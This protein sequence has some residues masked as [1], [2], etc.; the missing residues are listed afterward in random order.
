MLERS[1][2]SPFVDPFLDS[3]VLTARAF[4][5]VIRA[6]SLVTLFFGEVFPRLS[7]PWPDFD[8]SGENVLLAALS[9]GKTNAV[10]H[11]WPIPEVRNDV[12][13]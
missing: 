13:E 3:V 10:F 11:R 2:L 6:I 8:P 5:V 12:M 9:I 4:V 1:N 7:R